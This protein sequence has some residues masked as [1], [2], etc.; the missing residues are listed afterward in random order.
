MSHQR[1]HEEFVALLTSEGVPLD[2]C[3]QVMR[4]ATP[5]LGRDDE[6]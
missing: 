3:R 4:H 6:W 2:V 1:D 5:D